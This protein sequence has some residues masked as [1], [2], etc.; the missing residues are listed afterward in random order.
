VLVALLAGGCAPRARPGV[1]V[2]AAPGIV[3]G[4][5]ASAAT[6]VRAGASAATGVRAVAV[7]TAPVQLLPDTTAVV[8]SIAGIGALLAV[9][10][11]DALVAKFRPIYEQGATLLTGT[12]GVNLLDP[13]QWSMI[14]VDPRG[15]MGAALVDVRA[16]TFVAYATISDPARLRGFIDLLGHLVSHAF[17]LCLHGIDGRHGVVDHALRGLLRLLLHFVDCFLGLRDGS[18]RGVADR[19]LC[20]LHRVLHRVQRVLGRIGRGGLRIVQRGHRI[21]HRRHGVVGQCIGLVQHAV[22]LIQQRTGHAVQC[23]HGVS[24]GV[25]GL[26]SAP[27]QLILQ[28]AHVGAIRCGEV[29]RQVGETRGQ[30]IQRGADLAKDV[31]RLVHHFVTR[32]LQ[33]LGCGVA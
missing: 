32:G 27:C 21:V 17:G 8:L 9:V 5:G 23:T 18:F 10:D 28:G 11:V 30:G 15:P 31:T 3:P 20:L 22:R 14:G 26:G 4:A 25:V 16:S 1:A 19:L 2:S 24:Q 7:A 12:F 33:H 29:D 13:A 6:G